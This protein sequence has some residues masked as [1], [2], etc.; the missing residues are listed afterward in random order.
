MVIAAAAWLPAILAC[1]E[2]ILQSNNN[3][4]AD[5]LHARGRG[6]SRPA[7][8][9]RTRR[10]LDLISDRHRVLLA[11][12]RTRAWRLGGKDQGRHHRYHDEILGI[13]LSAVQ[14]IPLF[15]LAQNNFRS[16]SVT[17][18]QVHSWAY[19]LKQ[20]LTFFI[21]IFSATR[22]ITPISTCSI[23]SRT[24]RPPARSFGEPKTMSR[25][26]HTLA[27]CPCCSRSSHSSRSFG[28]GESRKL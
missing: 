6:Y 24:Q 12:A 25:P 11:L 19:P 17:Y 23:S 14:L 16:G 3:R 5:L 18:D 1:V 20:I 10:N 28:R 21:P 13:A 4:P 26:A 8:S 27:Y 15:E 9:R 22:R 7:I 2:L